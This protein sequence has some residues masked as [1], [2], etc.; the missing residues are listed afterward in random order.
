MPGAETLVSDGQETVTGMDSGQSPL[1]IREDQVAWAWNCIFTLNYPSCRPTWRHLWTLKVDAPEFSACSVKTRTEIDLGRFQGAHVFYPDSGW[2]HLILCAGGRVVS[3]DGNLFG[4]STAGWTIRDHG[5]QFIPYAEWIWGQ[6][7]ENFFVLQDGT[8]MPRIYSDGNLRV[9]GKPVV[10]E[11]NEI[12]PG[13]AMGFCNGRL[14]VASD[15]GRSFL[16][17]DITRGPSG[18]SA[19]SFRDA[20]LKKTENKFLAQGGRFAVPMAAGEIN[21][22][23]QLAQADVPGNTGP[24]V[25]LTQEGAYGLNLPVE[26]EQWADL[27]SP[28][29][30]ILAN[31]EGCVGPAAFAMLNG[32][33]IFRSP[34]GIRT[35]RRGYRDLSSG[36][37]C[38][39]LSWELYRIQQ[40]TQVG[41]L[42]TASAAFHHY[43]VLF[44]ELPTNYVSPDPAGNR[45]RGIIFP[46][47]SVLLTAGIS[48]INQETGP[49]WEGIWTGLNLFQVMAINVNRVPRLVGVALDSTE[50]IAFYELSYDHSQDLGSTKQEQLVQWG[51]ETRSLFSKQRLQRKRLKD[52]EMG[53]TNIQ[54]DVTVKV[55][56]RQ[57]GHINWQVWGQKSV[58]LPKGGCTTCAPQVDMSGNVTGET[59]V[60]LFNLAPK[61]AY[62][63]RFGDPTDDDC[64]TDAGRPMPEMYAIQLRVEVTGHCAVSYLLARAVVLPRIEAYECTT[65]VLA[66]QQ[67]FCTTSNVEYAYR[68]P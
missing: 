52:L 3:A 61:A 8:I 1:L 16:A 11:T 49:A 62:P 21:A 15:D 59:G 57:H 24:V 27:R 32:D 29:V 48:G 40:Q 28:P 25:L 58:K 68:I 5:Q 19:Y 36:W 33:L 20:V 54:T 67:G 44:T 23:V 30:T 18:N 26:R 56:Y 7:A 50:R 55:L 65:E 22:I 51:F 64:L 60:G 66:G 10:G 41:F 9:A 6:Q 2:P 46:W 31:G 4:D 43:R 39:H 35:L 13:R 47:T 42:R 38:R 12:T 34:T 45:E 53:L 14:W 63:I 37:A 17:G